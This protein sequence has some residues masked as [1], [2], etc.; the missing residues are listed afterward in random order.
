VTSDWRFRMDPYQERLSRQNAEAERAA[1]ARI[2]GEQL[3]VAVDA[4]ADATIGSVLGR[5]VPELVPPS[6]YDAGLLSAWKCLH[7][8][9]TVETEM[10]KGT[11]E[12]RVLGTALLSQL[13]S[14][15]SPQPELWL[16]V[17]RKAE[18]LHDGWRLFPESMEP[19]ALRAHGHALS[20]HAPLDDPNSWIEPLGHLRNV[21][22]WKSWLERARDQEKGTD[23]WAALDK[24]NRLAEELQVSS[25]LHQRSVLARRAGLDV[26][27]RWLGDLPAAPLAQSAMR[28]L[29]SLDEARDLLES[30][31]RSDITEGARV[32]VVALAVRRTIELC[33]QLW[34]NLAHGADRRWAMPGEAPEHQTRCQ[35]ALR[36]WKDREL[37]ERAGAVAQTLLEEGAIGRAVSVMALRHLFQNSAKE[38]GRDAR[39]AT[40]GAFRRAL[41]RAFVDRKQVGVALLS[42]ILAPMP[43]RGA[44]LAGSRPLLESDE[45][46]A[47]ERTRSASLLLESYASWLSGSDS[48]WTSPLRDDELELAWCVAGVVA[49][50]EQPSDAVRDLLCRF[51]VP[52]EGWKHDSRRYLES[53][54]VIAHVVVVGAMASEWCFT[55]A[56]N[57]S[58]LR[59]YDVVWE[60]M[61]RWLRASALVGPSDDMMRS[62]I[63]HLWARAPLVYGEAVNA[64]ALSALESLDVLDWLLVAAI[65]LMR[66]AKTP[67]YKWDPALQRVIRKRFCEQMPA[68]RHRHG[69]RSET[70]EQLTKDH[71]ELTPD[72]PA[73]ESCSI[74]PAR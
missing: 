29:A 55:H 47:T 36:E 17:F 74:L 40:S 8:V 16:A 35:D 46:E 59:T 38:Y 62:A 25:D 66:N 42:E 24:T 6:E 18:R 4:L 10:P 56:R 70:L 51:E 21:A 69:V 20:K 63:A 60:F 32:L 71:A 11:A 5:P 52:A 3:S 1:R 41:I 15:V 9:L 48:W 57:D 58:A 50:T 23:L 45:G 64:R 43:V 14:R 67:G 33:E 44:V 2:P 28:D 27:V 72:L 19:E 13:G 34:L 30:A 61:I 53:R 65:H 37:A 12:E 26:W 7:A 54:P 68:M 39:V 22:A 73:T 49:E 31:L